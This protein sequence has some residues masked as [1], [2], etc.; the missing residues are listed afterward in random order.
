MKRKIELLGLL[1][2]L[3]T[4]VPALAQ[5]NFFNSGG[6]TTPPG[7][8]GNADPDDNGASSSSSSGSSK[9][10]PGMA[11]GNSSGGDYT[12][13]EK[14]MQAK[15]K[16]NVRHAKGLIEKGDSMMKAANGNTNHKDYKK[17]KLFK[18]IGEKSLADLSANNPFPEAE[19]PVKAGKPKDANKQEL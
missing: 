19:K 2:I 6:S 18:E 15:Y 12:S 1:A 4:S 9:P 14:R 3:A 11:Q 10:S 8:V 17:G 13:D 5:G 7:A 16:A